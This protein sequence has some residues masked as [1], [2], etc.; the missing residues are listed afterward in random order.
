MPDGEQRQQKDP[1]RSA[2]DQDERKVNEAVQLPAS[3][4]AGAIMEVGLV[5]AAH[6]G[7]Q[8]GDV[9]PPSGEDVTHNFVSAHCHLKVLTQER[10]RSFKL[11]NGAAVTFFDRLPDATSQPLTAASIL[12]TSIFCI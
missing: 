12:A 1:R 2:G 4:A 6:L 8:P 5:I 7:S 10:S 9:I 11:A 3:A